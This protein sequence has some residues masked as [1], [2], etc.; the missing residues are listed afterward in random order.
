VGVSLAL[1]SPKDA[2]I[3]S[4]IAAITMLLGP[5]VAT[6]TEA[7]I[8]ARAPQAEPDADDFTNATGSVLIVGFGRFGQIVSQCF[9]TQGVDVTAVDIDTGMIDAAGRFGFRVYYGDGRRLDVLRAAGAGRVPMIAVCVDDRETATQIVDVVNEQFPD[10]KL[11]VRAF[12][13]THTLELIRKGVNFELR[14]TL[15]SALAFGAAALAGLGVDAERAEA[16]ADDVRR[17]DL[18]RLALQKAGGLLVGTDVWFR[19]PQ[20]EPLVLPQRRARG[21]NPEAEAIVRE[22]ERKQAESARADSG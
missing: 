20:P 17:R 10:T 13:R 16:V 7:L 12:D 11:Y 22:A 21:I 14:E 19:K 4:A 2:S 9:L 18:E 15:E 8:R 6:A 3:V 1:L 5:L